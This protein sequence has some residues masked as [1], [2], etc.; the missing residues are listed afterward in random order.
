MCV[1]FLHIVLD[2]GILKYCSLSLFVCFQELFCKQ[3]G[4]STFILGIQGFPLTSHI[5]A[6]IAF[7]FSLLMFLQTLAEFDIQS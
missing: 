7:M 2:I 1:H 3:Q 6:G 5:H 4:S